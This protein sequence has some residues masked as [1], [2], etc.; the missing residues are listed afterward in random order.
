MAYCKYSANAQDSMDS[1][2]LTTG[3]LEGQA[4]KLFQ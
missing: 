4:E 3:D 1:N 2:L